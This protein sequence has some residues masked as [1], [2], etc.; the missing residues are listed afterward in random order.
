MLIQVLGPGC[1]R[2]K[3]L[4]ANAEAAARALGLDFELEKVTDIQQIVAFG[5]MSTPAIVIDGQVK[6]AGQVPSVADLT[7]LLQAASAP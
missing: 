7:A 1:A 5:V 3:T 2:C 4:A 6:L